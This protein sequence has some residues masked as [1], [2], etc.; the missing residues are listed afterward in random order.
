MARIALMRTGTVLYADNAKASNVA[1]NQDALGVLRYLKQTGHSVCIFGRAEGDFGVPVYDV[2]LSGLDEDSL[3]DKWHE[4]IDKA[5]VDLKEW[6]PEVALNI[7]G[8]APT[9]S[10]PNNPFGT[11]TQMWSMRTVLPALK[12]MHVLD[13]PRIVVINDPRNYPKDHE[14]VYWDRCVP[15]AVLSQREFSWVRTVRGRKQHITEVYAGAEN[16]WSYGM[17]P[18]SLDGVREGAIILA[19]AHFADKRVNSRGTREDVWNLVIQSFAGQCLDIY[20]RGWDGYPQWCGELRHSEVQ[21][22]LVSYSGGPMIPIQSNFNSGKL[23]EYVLA[24][25]MPRPVTSDQLT[26]DILERYVP[27]NHVSRVHAGVEWREMWDRDWI[28]HLR[29]ITTPDFTPLERCLAG[30]KMGGVEWLE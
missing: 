6:K 2:N 8:A 27:L 10:D 28:E 16:W 11:L 5:I 24:G 15:A 21:D 12:A 17:S 7:A 18:K 26:Y 29:E 22:K 1:G 19:H 25:C 4:R 3:G 20:G 30:E 14:M 23:R 9:I 13:L